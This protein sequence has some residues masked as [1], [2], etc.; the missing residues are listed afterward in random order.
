MIRNAVMSDLGALCALERSLFASDRLSRRALRYHIRSRHA[1]M[2]CDVVND[3]MRGYGLALRYESQRAAR[4][5]SLAV[6]PDYHGQGIA[7]G[8][9]AALEATCG[10]S[11][12]R[13]E[14][15]RDNNRARA[16]YEK[17][18]YVATATRNDF[19]SD[20]EAAILMKKGL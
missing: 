4:L 11:V 9:I 8:L 20:G 16:F 2:M 15:R 10:K 12:I 19:Y 1:V 7:G 14:V 17:Q 6:D 18:G 13:L 5:Y 3:R